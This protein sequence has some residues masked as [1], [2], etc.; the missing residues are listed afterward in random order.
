VKAQ[1]AAA[2]LL[3]YF[4]FRDTALDRYPNV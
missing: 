3:S 1:A 2:S 4:C